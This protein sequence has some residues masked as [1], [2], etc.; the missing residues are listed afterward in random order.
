LALLRAESWH[1]PEQNFL[2][3]QGVNFLPQFRQ[4]DCFVIR[5]P[6]AFQPPGLGHV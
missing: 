3:R 1:R 6:L 2:A 4:V 5:Q